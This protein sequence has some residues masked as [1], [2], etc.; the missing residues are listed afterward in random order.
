MQRELA[1]DPQRK[2]SLAELARSY[3][4]ET[5][6][7]LREVQAVQSQNAAHAQA[8]LEAFHV[9]RTRLLADSGRAAADLLTEAQRQRLDEVLFRLRSIEVFDIPE[10]IAALALTPDQQLAL[11]QVRIEL[12]AAAR[13]LVEQKSAGAIATE[14]F[15]LGVGEI[16]RQ[17]EGKAAPLLT[18][19]QAAQMG[20]WSGPP[21]PFSRQSLRLEIRAAAK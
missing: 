8:T 1:I 7:H 2:Q 19:E 13:Q 16:L 9:H 17:A 6:Q 10:F 11:R 15:N 21:I 5:A 3:A 14:E 20:A 12:E 4:D 18:V